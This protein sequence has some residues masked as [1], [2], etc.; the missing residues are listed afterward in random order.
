MYN[1]EGVL[2][3]SSTLDLVVLKAAELRNV[4]VS[5]IFVHERNNHF[6]T[7]SARRLASYQA[8]GK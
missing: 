5:V 1:I 2:A 8:T 3:S 7:N 4:A 6:R